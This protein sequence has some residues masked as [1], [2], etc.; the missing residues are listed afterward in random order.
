[1]SLASQ[2]EEKGHGAEKTFEEIMLGNILNLAKHINL[3]ITEADLTPTHKFKY[4]HPDAHYSLTDE[5]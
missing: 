3:R 5:N 4:I 1:M 2:K